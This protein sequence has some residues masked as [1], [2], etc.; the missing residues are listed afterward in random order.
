MRLFILALTL[1][2]PLAL[3]GCA[4]SPQEEAMEEGAPP[5]D[6]EDVIGDGEIID[7]PGEPEGNMFMSWDTNADGNLDNTE[8]SAGMAGEDMSMYD[9]DGNGMV[10]QAEYDAYMMAHPSM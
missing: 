2:V 4:E 1:A 7:E 6:M 8:F 9:T 5:G 10:S 3:T